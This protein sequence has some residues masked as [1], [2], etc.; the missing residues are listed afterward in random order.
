M[1]TSFF[2]KFRPHAVLLA[3][4]V[5]SAP[6]GAAEDK[7]QPLHSEVIGD[8]AGKILTALMAPLES[9]EAPDGDWAEMLAPGCSIGA[10]RPGK[11]SSSWDGAEASVTRHAAGALKAEKGAQALLQ[12]L[13]SL[14]KAW[15]ETSGRHVKFKVLRVDL[16]PAPQPVKTLQLFSFTAQT[17]SGP[18][19]H[20]ATWE[21]E[22]TLSGTSDA[23]EL[24]L[25]SLRCLSVEE[26]RAKKGAWFTDC[27]ESLLA[28]LPFFR[29][30]ACRS[31]AWWRSRLQKQFEQFIYGHH[32]LAVGD[33]NGDGL[34][35]VYLCAGGGVPNRLILQQPDGTVKD[36]SR[37]L[38]L[39][40]LD[41]TRAAV[42]ADLDSE[43]GRAHV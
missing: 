13:Q 10:L 19:E 21:A 37:E 30:Q 31:N 7:F 32:G 23:P 12:Q 17:P 4:V 39:D 9:G 40:Y 26:A 36:A 6:A 28:P 3:V 8:K 38:G 25:K 14:P 35:D 20:N 34:D 33:V 43:I 42:F 24:K 11:S 41:H 16:P 22:W 5:A 27:T 18:A 15:G 1:S 29:E 2:R